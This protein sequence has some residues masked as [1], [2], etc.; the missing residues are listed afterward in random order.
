MQLAIVKFLW[1]MLIALVFTGGLKNSCRQQQDSGLRLHR[2]ENRRKFLKGD[3]ASLE[4]A[5]L[6]L[7][8][9]QQSPVTVV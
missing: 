7:R 3:L 1:L 9:L 4:Q 6:K 2:C 5:I 8:G